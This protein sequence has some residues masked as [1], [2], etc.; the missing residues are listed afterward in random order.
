MRRKACHYGGGIYLFFHVSHLGANLNYKSL[1]K[2][3]EIHHIYLLIKIVTFKIFFDLIY[4]LVIFKW[5]T[6][7]KP[8]YS[9]RLESAA[10]LHW[11]KLVPYKASLLSVQIKADIICLR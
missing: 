1:H 9:A 7:I 10:S 3:R 8:S 11:V 4:T 5:A 2:E 6:L